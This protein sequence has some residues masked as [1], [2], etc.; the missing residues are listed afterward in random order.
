MI[1]DLYIHI[2]NNILINGVKL[3]RIY[4]EGIDFIYFLEDLQ[5]IK[6]KDLKKCEIYIECCK[7]NKLFKI[8]SIT[9]KHLKDAYISKSFQT[10]ERNKNR[11][12]SEK[13]LNKLKISCSKRS[14][15][16]NNAM[17][18]KKHS[19]EALL[20]ISKSVKYRNTIEYWCDKGF[21]T[22]EANKKMFEYKQNIANKAASLENYR[23]K[24]PDNW[25]QKY[26]EFCLSRIQSKEKFIKL[27]GELLGTEK[28]DKYSA[29][30]R[31]KLMELSNK[32]WSKISQDF[33]WELKE[34]LND[35]NITCIFATNDNNTRND[36]TNK[37]YKIVY[38]G[39]DKTRWYRLDF[40][41]PEINFAIELD[42]F[43]W[44]NIELDRKRQKHIEL[45]IPNIYFHRINYKGYMSQM[46]KMGFLKETYNL[47]KQK[48]E[49]SKDSINQ[50][51]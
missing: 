26:N 27:Y 8:K 33:F 30:K 5:K 45:L 12:W 35:F 32:G 37:E 29:L 16:E 50:K 19:A 48:Y 38:T 14:S 25:K 3:V 23:I 1:N 44:H 2:I 6:R 43:K 13:S 9:K 34:M 47:I 39:N 36:K 18:G 22:D 40:Y 17:Y 21:S 10:S 51:N 24:Y 11:V 31:N 4:S 20:K 15:S 42:C 28:Y 41:I 7:C 49:I 46:E